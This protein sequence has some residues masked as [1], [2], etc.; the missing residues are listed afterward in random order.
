MIK[1]VFK[2]NKREVPGNLPPLVWRDKVL[3]YEQMDLLELAWF[4][5]VMEYL[6]PDELQRVKAKALIWREI[7]G[8][9]PDDLAYWWEPRMARR[10]GDLPHGDTFAL[11]HIDEDGVL[12]CGHCAARWSPHHDGSPQATRC[13]LCDVKWIVIQEKILTWL[14]K[15]EDSNGDA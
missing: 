4:H 3:E 14:A 13:K 7:T 1:T 6:S 9:W 8:E 11:A 10:R 15:T 2:G 5:P 12:H